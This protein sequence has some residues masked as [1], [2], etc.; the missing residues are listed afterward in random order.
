MSQH[1]QLMLQQQV[2]T[3]KVSIFLTKVYVLES[4]G[5]LLQHPSC[6]KVGL[7]K[8]DT[9]LEMVES[10]KHESTEHFQEKEDNPVDVLCYSVE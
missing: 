10:E 1:I 6:Y 7:C 8:P 4:L 2:L 3:G 9:A 5:F